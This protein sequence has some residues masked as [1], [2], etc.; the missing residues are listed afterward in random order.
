MLETI[1]HALLTKFIWNRLWLQLAGSMFGVNF[2]YT[3]SWNAINGIPSYAVARVVCVK[4]LIEIPYTVP[5]I[6]AAQSTLFH[7]IFEHTWKWIW[8]HILTN[9]AAL[10]LL[11]MQSIQVWFGKKYL[12]N[13]RALKAWQFIALKHLKSRAKHGI[14]WK[15]M[16]CIR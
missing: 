1:A 8:N 14:R 2:W 4:I 12:L 7:L 13:V 15:D 11:N 3:Y 10:F 5:R 16:P 6:A 9:D